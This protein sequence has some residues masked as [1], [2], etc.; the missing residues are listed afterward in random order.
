MCPLSGY[1]TRGIASGDVNGDGRDD[2]AVTMQAQFDLFTQMA[3]GTLAAAG[4]SLW[5]PKARIADVTSDGRAD[6]VVIGWDSDAVSV[7]AQTAAGTLSGPTN[8]NVPLSGYNDLE[9]ADVDGDGDNDI[10]AMSGQLY[11]TPDVTVLIQGGGGMGTRSYLVPGG[12]VHAHGVGVGDIDGDGLGE[13][14]VSHGDNRPSP[15]VTVFEAA[16]EEPDGGRHHRRIRNP[17]ARRGGRLQPGRLRRVAVARGGWHRISVLYRLQHRPE[18]S[19]RGARG[20]LRQPLRGA[21]PAGRRPR[22]GRRRRTGGGRLQQGRARLP[23]PGRRRAQGGRPQPLIVLA[24]YICAGNTDDHARN[25]AAFW[26]GKMLALTPAYD[27]CS[28]LRS[29]QK[30]RQALAIRP[31]RLALQPA[32]RLP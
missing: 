28:Q 29:G 21:R 8:Y 18:P 25:R 3:T 1:W 16:A 2:V 5:R 9:V 19:E 12:N 32:G 23:Q 13:V 11:A 26:D 22:R 30:A 4:L 24:S 17:R 31:R 15:K 10:V 7:Y 27:V 20:P 14:V 6:V